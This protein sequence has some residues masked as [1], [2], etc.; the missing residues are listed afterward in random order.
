MP[1]RVLDPNQLG[2][3]IVDHGSRRDESNRM[4]LEVVEMFRRLT[5]Y[6]IVEPAHME[7]A[8]PSIQTAFGRC[9]E[10][11]A[12]LVV[13]HPY[14]LLP[15]RHWHQDIPHLAGEAAQKHAGVDF[16][17]TQPLGLHPLM[18]N[19]MQERIEASL[20]QLSVETRL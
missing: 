14:F 15:G 12:K 19:I 20:S 16:A 3:I 13:V 10:Q 6:A 11:G 1:Q 2:I 5:G 9:V 4:L 18:A 8:D 17:V 7:L